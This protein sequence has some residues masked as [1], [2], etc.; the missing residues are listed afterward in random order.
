[1]AKKNDTPILIAAFLITAALISFG[2]WWLTRQFGDNLGGIVS[3]GDSSSST[4]SS[5]PASS[6]VA[7]IPSSQNFASVASVPSGVFSYGGSTTWAPVRGMIDPVIQQ[8]HPGFQLRYTDPVGGA[9]SSGAGIQ[10]LLNNQIGFSQSSRSLSPQEIQ[11]AQQR[12]FTLREIPVALEGIAIA[13][14]PDL[15]V[16]GLTIAQ[17][18]DI[19]T[20]Q[21]DNWSQVG[22]P[23]LAIAPYSRPTDGGTVEFF[24]SN[25]MG[26]GNFGGTVRIVSTTTEALRAVASNTGSI[27]FAS[28]PEVI[29]QCTTKPL[30]IGNSSSTLIAPYQV[31]LVPAS[32]CPAQR[33]QMNMA[34]LQTGEYPLTRRLLVIVK[35]NGQIDQQAGE[36]YAT[37]LLSQ[38]GQSL[39]EQA[40]FVPIR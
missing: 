31:P 18:R 7:D 1:M 12:N 38:E 20:G 30:P 15:S 26:G 16:E 39:L 9:P 3:D 27:Y 17:L 24:I 19:Y 14:H 34:A 32:Q 4:T 35:E 11:A 22:G 8:A 13:V 6:T 29:G 10:M 23:N 21:I 33:N 2:G 5:S 25:V 37:L 36:A 28:A 40:G